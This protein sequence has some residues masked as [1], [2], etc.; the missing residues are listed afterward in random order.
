MSSPIARPFRG[1]M[2]PLVT[3]LSD[4]YRLDTGSLEKLIDH[5]IGGGVNGV[6]IAGTTGEGVNVSRGLKERMV[7][8][9]CRRAGNRAP[10]VV[11]VSDCSEAESIALARVAADSGAAAVAFTPPYYGE[12]TEEEIRR[13]AVRLGDE[14]PV[15]FFLY[16]F[17]S[18]TRNSYSLDTVKALLA[19]DKCA[20]IKDSSGDMV[21][22]KELLRLVADYPES[23]VLLGPEEQMPEAIAAGAPGAVSGGANLAPLWFTSLYAAATAGDAAET[24]KWHA[25]TMEISRRI[26]GAIQEPSGYMRGLKCA[27]GLMGL[28]SPECAPPLAPVPDAIRDQIKVALIELGLLG[29]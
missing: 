10:V 16:N 8:E 29:N 21:Y 26:Y 3:P 13:H 4:P 5:V 28:C 2:V 23:S 18:C 24:A 12:L 9:T 15:P 11:C 1:I 22:F 19:H 25:K 14:L 27:L 6:F 17:P 20:G 7:R